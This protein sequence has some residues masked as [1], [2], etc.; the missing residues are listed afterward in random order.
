ME[1]CDGV[2]LGG[3][4]CQDQGYYEGMLRCD[5][6]MLDVSLCEGTC[7]DG[8][9]QR[10]F[11]EMCDGLDLGTCLDLDH[12]FG[13]PGCDA[14]CDALPGDCRDIELRGTDANDVGRGLAIDTLGNVYVAGST[15]GGLDGQTPLGSGDN[16]LMKFDRGGTHLWTRQWG[17][18]GNEWAQGVAVDAAGAVFVCGSTNGSLDGQTG[19]GQY[20]NYLSKFQPDG[21]HLWTRQWGNTGNQY[22]FHVALDAA[23]NA[24][25]TGYTEGGLDGQTSAGSEDI[26][27]TKF[28]PDGTRLWTRQWG[29]SVNDNGTAVVADAGGVAYV[30]GTVTAALPGLSHA[31]S[32]DV[33]LTRYEADGTW[34]WSRQMGTGGGDFAKDIGLDPAGNVILT[35]HTE[36]AID[37][38]SSAGSVDAFFTK[39][40]PSGVRQLTR[41]WG[42]GNADYTYGIAADAAGNVFVCGETQA[43][44]DGQP[45]QGMSDIFLTKFD[46]SGVRLWTRQWGTASPDLAWA[47]ALDALGNAFVTGYT[48]GALGGRTYGGA[49]DVYLLF[50]PVE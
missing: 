40:S 20:D 48:A 11:G 18:T 23:G 46:V 30:T 2:N 8:I 1:V 50:S 29:T 35:G 4:T 27:L 10:A 9:A 13:T 16:F 22:A 21:T 14:G 37:G 41:Q 32:Y 44:L 7:G 26:F 49:N 43:S 17:T 24:Y 45:F 42:N 31:G 5:G 12:F 38:Q 36:G 28:G 47:L 3:E 25:V 6:C 19:A 33:F 15:E 39:Y 34:A